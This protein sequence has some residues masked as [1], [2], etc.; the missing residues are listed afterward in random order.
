MW[1]TVG[2]CHQWLS[3]PLIG[4]RVC[5]LLLIDANGDH[6]RVV[7]EDA[8]EEDSEEEEPENGEAANG[9]GT[10]DDGDEEEDD[11]DS[12][13]I[14]DEADEKGLEVKEDLFDVERS[15]WIASNACRFGGG[16]M[17]TRRISSS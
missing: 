6:F 3:S 8:E 2:H 16:R 7:A 10:D 4:K 12:E 17:Y 9:G 11:D 14:D 13:Q 15:V 5:H 1:W